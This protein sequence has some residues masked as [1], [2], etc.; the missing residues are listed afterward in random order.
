MCCCDF[1]GVTENIESKHLENEDSE[2]PN[3]EEPRVNQEQDVNVNSTNN[4]NTISPTVNAADIENNAVDENIVYGCIDDP[5]TPNLEEIVYFDDD[6]E[7]GA[8]AGMNNL[9]TTVPVSPIPTTRVH[10]D[11]P[12][13]QIIKDIQ[14]APQTRKMTK[15][16]TEH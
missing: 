1:W 13:K 15:N 3:T 7:V 12:L 14:S 10:K 8:E 6:E 11:H 4:I 2:V 16:V 9:A 5:N